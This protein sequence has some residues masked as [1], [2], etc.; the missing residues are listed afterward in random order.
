MEPQ[1]GALFLLVHYYDT[2]DPYETP[3][4]FNCLLRPDAALRGIL[5]RRDLD[6]VAYHEV[7]NHEQQAAAGE[8]TQGEP[9]LEEMVAHYDASVRLVT[10]RLAGLVDLWD[11]S[12]R[13][14]QSLVIITSDHGEGLGQHGFWS[15]GMNVHDEALRIPMLVRFPAGMRPE[16]QADAPVSLLD[17][18]PTVLH[19]AGL[20]LPGDLDGGSL[21][22]GTPR[23]PTFV[24]QRMRY[25]YRDRPPGVRNWRAGDGFAITEGD[26]KLVVEFEGPAALYNL[27][28]DPLETANLA[29]SGGEVEARMRR[30]LDDWLTAHP[31]VAAWPPAPPDAE[32]LRVLKSLGYVDP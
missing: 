12:G 19:A 13:G 21:A 30:R 25:L 23:R 31:D 17:V 32:R 6:A 28:V 14:D 9:S 27:A 26:F 24:A 10:D 15:H 22:A 1:G 18:A 20:P 8:A 16:V 5:S 7:L 29:G 11:A 3:D 2:H 4:R